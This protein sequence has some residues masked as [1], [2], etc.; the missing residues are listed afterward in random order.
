[1][2]ADHGFVI[3]MSEAANLFKE[4][5]LCKPFEDTIIE[6]LGKAA[7][8]PGQRQGHGIFVEISHEQDIA[9]SNDQGHNRDG[10]EHV[11]RE[12]DA[13]AAVTA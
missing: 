3:D 13:A 7:L 10:G 6:G 9:A 12:K 11:S 8:V 2:R 5:R 1:M 4:V